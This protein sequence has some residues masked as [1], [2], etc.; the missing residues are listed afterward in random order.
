[1]DITYF[2]DDENEVTLPSCWEI[3]DHCRGE[4]RSSAYLGAFTR[5]ELD[6]DPEFFE[7][8]RAGRYDR[9]C[10]ECGGSGK[11]KVVDRE[12]ADP[13]ALEAYDA[14]QRELAE[15]RAIE[16]AERAMGA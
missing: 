9:T 11:V 4:G 16:R 7:D 2:D 5:D 13:A 1:M 15:T 14:Q 12:S 3:C 6:D 10:E 8:Y